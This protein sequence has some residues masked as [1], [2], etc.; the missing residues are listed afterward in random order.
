MIA[1][2]FLFEGR[3]G[4]SD[5]LNPIVVKELRQAVQSRFVVAAL[6]ALL[7][8]QIFAIGLF[9]LSGSDALLNF[10]SGREVFMI[11]FAILFAVS[12]LFVP[13]YTG[14]R[15]AAERS[16]T[17]V[18]LLFITTIKPRGIIAGK[19]LAA[20][21]LAVLIFSACMPFMTFTYF[22]RGIDLPS[23]FIPLA[24]AFVIVIGC[25]QAAV[26]IACMPIN[27]AFK[28]VLAIIALIAFTVI[29]FMTL[30]WAGRIFFGGRI[31]PANQWEG[32]LI[33]FTVI[34]FLTGLCFAL[35]TALIMPIAA[36]RALPARLFVTIAWL[37]TGAAA[38]INGAVEDAHWPVTA[39]QVCFNLVFAAAL[40]VAVSERDQLG[41]RVRRAIPPSPLKRLPAFFLFSGA[42]SGLV[43][44][45][46]MIVLTLMV[47][48]I[49][50][51]IFSARAGLGELVDSAKWMGGMCLYFFCYAMSGALLRRRVL[52]R[53]P[54]EWTWLVSAALMGVG[55]TLPVV[56]GYLLFFDDNSWETLGK[57]LTGNPFAYGYKGHRV[58]YT[59]VGG[60]WAALVAALSLPWFIRRVQQFKPVT[61]D[62]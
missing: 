19:M 55:S 51:H 52:G 41:L 59:T 27:R 21:V 48:W 56:I 14:V 3:P 9:L 29:Y 2:T 23:I 32:M 46:A 34:A 1:E 36:N 62:E 12:L 58:L 57:S 26:L 44:A 43:W 37:L 24:L 17:N 30:T 15:L 16:D 49:C 39:W 38:L 45:S 31:V 40:L 22:L 7:V 61:R 8:I 25:T 47:V 13:L 50:R 33:L 11:L 35:S 4:W 10:D 18:D 28:V 54:T 53:M 5:R 60:I 42:A 20:V 6:L